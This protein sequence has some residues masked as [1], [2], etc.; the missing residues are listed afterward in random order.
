MA[1]APPA[2]PFR[3]AGL[4]DKA[5]G[6]VLPL[7]RRTDEGRSGTGTRLVLAADDEIDA[8]DQYVPGAV[9]RMSFA[10]SVSMT[11]IGGIICETSFP[12]G[13]ATF[14]AD[15]QPESS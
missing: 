6:D 12:L 2:I 14:T 9:S 15:G 11:L 10:A 3:P 1:A 4:I 5:H 8:L 7:T 13:A